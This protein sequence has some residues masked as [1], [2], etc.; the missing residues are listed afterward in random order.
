[1]PCGET[2]HRGRALRHRF[3]AGVTQFLSNSSHRSHNAG[4]TSNDVWCGGQ[5]ASTL[6]APSD[7][8]SLLAPPGRCL[9][10]KVMLCAGSLHCRTCSQLSCSQVADP[11]VARCRLRQLHRRKKSLKASGFSRPWMGNPLPISW[12]K[13]GEQ[14]L[15]GRQS[16]DHRA[17]RT[18]HPS[19]DRAVDSTQWTDQ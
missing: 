3:Y 8:P 17:G 5:S 16:A 18:L 9:P 15:G 6:D 4:P 10:L 7:G 2:S 13:R 14:I 19:I 11:T 1:M 12:H